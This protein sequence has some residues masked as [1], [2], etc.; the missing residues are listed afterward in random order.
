MF[1]CAGSEAGSGVGVNALMRS[2]GTTVAG[3]VMAAI[4]LVVNVP[5]TLLVAPQ[6]I[7]VNGDP[8]LGGALT[9]RIFYWHVPAAWAAYLAFFV[10]FVASLGW[11][12][13]KRPW[14]D[15]LAV[16]SLPAHVVIDISHGN[17][18]RDHARQP[19]V[20]REVAPI[21]VRPP[22][23]PDGDADGAVGGEAAAERDRQPRLALG[24]VRRD[25]ELEELLA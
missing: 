13:T 16:A 20:A 25:G 11:L 21:H 24:D 1:G 8:D 10:V 5:L 18:L 22:D 9:Q 6:A 15:A 3:A 7:D 23:V 4:L 2:V 14:F 17:S 12:L 19:V